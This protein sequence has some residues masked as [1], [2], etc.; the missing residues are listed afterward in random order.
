METDYCAY[1]DIFGEPGTGIHNYRIF[2]IAIFDVAGTLLLSYALSILFDQSY[3][4]MTI[5]VFLIGIIIHAAM[6]VR[7]KIH[8]FIFE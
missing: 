8:R 4:L 5:I 7:T 1:S 3:V 6:C 2:D